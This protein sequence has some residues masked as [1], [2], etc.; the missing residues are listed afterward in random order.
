MS[1]LTLVIGNCNY[2]SWSLRPWLFL[3]QHGI[4]FEVRKIS[5]FTESMGQELA[6]YFSDGKVPVL[7]DD[8]LQVWDSLAILEYLAERFPECNGW[9]QDRE[10]RAQARSVCAEMHSSFPGLRR[11][12]PMNCRRKFPGFQPSQEALRDI[13]RVLSIWRY[14]RD[15]YGQGG[16]WLFGEFGIADCMYAPVVMRFVSYQ[17]PLEPVSRAYVDTLY[18]SPAASTWVN[19]GKAESEIIGEDEADWPSEPI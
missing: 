19:L 2:S 1:R 12:L 3:Q 4:D 11:E 13:Q 14:C 8:R 16:P 5:L 18:G 9:P 15:R 6:P 17:I 10:A 7:L